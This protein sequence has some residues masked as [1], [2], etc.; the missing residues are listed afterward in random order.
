MLA[1]ARHAAAELGVANADFIEG[2]V[3]SLPFP[4][5]SFGCWRCRRWSTRRERVAL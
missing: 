3:E 1:K 4:D 5:E 2:E